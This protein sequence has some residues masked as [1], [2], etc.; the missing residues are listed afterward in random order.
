MPGTTQQFTIFLL[1]PSKIIN[2]IFFL[3]AWSLHVLTPS[4]PA[5]CSLA[6]R[7]HGLQ[8]NSHLDLPKHCNLA[9]EPLEVLTDLLVL[10]TFS[11]AQVRLQLMHL[12]TL[13]NTLGVLFGCLWKG[14]AFLR[15]AG[16]CEYVAVVKLY[17]STSLVTKVRL[18]NP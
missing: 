12:G 2:G 9:E 4:I 1:A 7:L 17:A 3:R 15:A 13:G 14:S 8:H 11:L 6:C 10:F 5:Y 18:R 16:W